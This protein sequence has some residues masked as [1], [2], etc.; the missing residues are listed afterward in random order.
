MGDTEA[1]QAQETGGARRG[2]RDQL[3]LCRWGECL[4]GAFGGK[5]PW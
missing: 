4:H 2:H 1:E 5:Y 3:L